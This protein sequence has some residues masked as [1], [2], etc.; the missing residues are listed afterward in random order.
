MNNDDQA[1]LTLLSTQ[2][3]LLN[4]LNM[5]KVNQRE[6]LQS[7]NQLS[8][9]IKRGSILSGAIGRRASVDLLRRLS[10]GLGNDD[11]I[12]QGFM[13]NDFVEPNNYSFKDLCDYESSFQAKK[14][15]RRRSSLALLSSLVV[16]AD[17][18]QS[19]RLSMMSS[20][21][22]AFADDMFE[23]EVVSFEVPEP[24]K[25]NFKSIDPSAHPKTLNTYQVFAS[26]MEKS[27]KSQQDIHDWDKKMGLK[28]S[29]SKTMRMTMRSRKKLRNLIKK[30]LVPRS[31]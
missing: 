16:H 6:Q 18:V 28:R 24:L 31:A 10:L 1:F 3:E 26:A 2:R 13:C 7:R 9:Q 20:L 25:N 11:Y 21:S 29:H 14:A 30:Q 8:P 4:Q 27:A 12:M 5:E 22:E 15:K 17:E 23:P 19:R